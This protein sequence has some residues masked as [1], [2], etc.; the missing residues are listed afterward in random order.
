MNLKE[1]EK[2]GQQLQEIGK[3]YKKLAKIM[4]QI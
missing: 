3:N 1:K 4:I 2:L